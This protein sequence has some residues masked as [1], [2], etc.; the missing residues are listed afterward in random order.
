MIS[1][2]TRRAAKRIVNTLCLKG[3]LEPK[4]VAAT[5]LF[6][7]SDDAPPVTGHEHFVDA[8]WR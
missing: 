2:G 7:A 8:V 6:L 5:A 3:R 4:D 1:I